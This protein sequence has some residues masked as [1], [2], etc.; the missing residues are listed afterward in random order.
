MVRLFNTVGPR[1][2]GSYG[3]VLPRFVGQA[4]SGSPITIHGDGKQS[5]CFGW[6][7]D[8]VHALID[9]SVREDAVGKI[10]NIGSDEE[11]SINQLASVIK[12]VTRSNSPI[13]HVP[14]E[15]VYGQGFRRHVPACSGSQPNSC[16]HRIPADQASPRNCAGR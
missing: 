11:V 6:V 9:L 8:V 12:E 15:E 10:F 4:L 13:H 16:S 14:Y 1:Q 3:M 7:G 2:T 5:R